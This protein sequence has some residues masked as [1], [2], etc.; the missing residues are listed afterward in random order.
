MIP[1]PTTGGTT[2]IPKGLLIPFCGHEQ[3]RHH[4]SD[5][6]SKLILGLR[7]G[8]HSTRH[9]PGPTSFRQCART[10]PPPSCKIPRIR[11]RCSTV[12]DALLLQVTRRIKLPNP[13]QISQPLCHVY[14]SSVDRAPTNT[15]PTCCAAKLQQC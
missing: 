7:L 11:P 10:S 15:S 4:K 12:L 13:H 1:P 3:R 5:S 14:C 9:L 6:C 2:G 8:Q